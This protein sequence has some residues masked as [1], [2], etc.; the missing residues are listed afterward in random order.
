MQEHGGRSRGEN[1]FKGQR[2]L[3][4]FKIQGAIKL[5]SLRYQMN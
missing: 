5:Q 4:E 2:A 1:D 3:R